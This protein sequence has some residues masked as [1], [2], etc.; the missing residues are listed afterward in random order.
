MQQSLPHLNW[1]VGFDSGARNSIRVSIL[2]TVDDRPINP[3]H[4]NVIRTSHFHFRELAP[5]VSA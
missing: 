3:D 1:F 4:L 5:G 2:L